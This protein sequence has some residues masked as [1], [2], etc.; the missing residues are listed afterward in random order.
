[1]TCGGADS[2][3]PED[4]NMIINPRL[5]HLVTYCD[6]SQSSDHKVRDLSVASITVTSI[7]RWNLRGGRHGNATPNSKH[8]ATRADQALT[9]FLD[10]APDNLTEDK[11]AY[12]WAKFKAYEYG[13]LTSTPATSTNRI[14]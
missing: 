1:M 4:N 3:N 14:S 5:R 12:F 7:L 13:F 8:F 2:Y 11:D 6:R 9:A 10:C